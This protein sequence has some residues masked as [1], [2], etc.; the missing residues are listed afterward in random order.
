MPL[1]PP[2]D[3][4]PGSR[5]RLPLPDRESLDE[6]GRQAWDRASRPGVIAGLQG[7]AGLQLQSPGIAPHLSALNTYLRFHAG[8]SGRVRELAILATARE[9]DSHFEWVA[10]EDVALK[11]G[12]SSEEIDVIRHRRDTAGLDAEAADVIGLARQ[13]W[14][15]HRVPPADFARLHARYGARQLMD[16]VVLMGTYAN[17]AAMLALVD[18]QLPEGRRSSLPVP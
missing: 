2:S 12:V 7:P 18:M 13:L 14:R 16:L 11:E 10:H 15:E 5:C 9:M 8:L 1:A 6:A 4:D 3:I 17:T